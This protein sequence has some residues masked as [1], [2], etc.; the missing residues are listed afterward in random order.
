MATDRITRR[1]F[2]ETVGISAGAA[3]L[4]GAPGHQLGRLGQ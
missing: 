2:V 1:D 3:T 4:L